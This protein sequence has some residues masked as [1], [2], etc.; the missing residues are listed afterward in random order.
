VKQNIDSSIISCDPSQLEAL[1]TS[2][3]NPN[4]I[5]FFVPPDVKAPPL[6]SGIG[7][8]GANNLNW[9][10]LMEFPQYGSALLLVLPASVFD[11]FHLFR[12][13]CECIMLAF[14]HLVGC[15][16]AAFGRDQ[17][18]GVVQKPKK[19]SNHLPVCGTC[20]PKRTGRTGRYMGYSSAV[21]RMHHVTIS[22]NRY[23]TT[24]CLLFALHREFS[25][26]HPAKL[27]SR[28]RGLMGW[29]AG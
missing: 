1:F 5:N 17:L 2:T 23:I 21:E 24:H 11:F 26:D 20:V 12:N 9:W 16:C 8:G 25:K 4:P 6:S 15:T 7:D 19:S 18:A 10:W 29:R 14:A 13:V 28:L 3:P 27:E 22:I